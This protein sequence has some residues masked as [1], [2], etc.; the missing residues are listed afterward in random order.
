MGL[1]NGIL[2]QWQNGDS[3]EW[4]PQYRYRFKWYNILMCSD[5]RQ[6][7]LNGIGVSE[8]IKESEVFIRRYCITWGEAKAFINSYKD[9]KAQRTRQRHTIVH[10][11]D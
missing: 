7:Y 3:V 1:N 4:I 10:T 5:F 11:V 2:E 6:Y 9:W 8:Y